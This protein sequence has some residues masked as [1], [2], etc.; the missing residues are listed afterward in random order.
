M[1]NKGIIVINKEEGYTSRD[2]VNIVSKYLK[3]KK[4]GHTGTLDPLAKGVLVVCFGK[5]TKLVPLLTSQEKTYIAE[6]KFGIKTDTLDITGKWQE[7][8][9][10]N[11]DLDKLKE[12]LN[13][14]KG[15]Y[16][17]EV[18]LYS[19]V[20]I[21]GKKLYEYARE[22]IEVTLPYKDVNIYDIKFIQYKDNIL[23]FYVV[24]EKGTYIR[25]LIKDICDKLKTIGT[26]NSLIRIKQ[27][28]FKIEDAYTL[29]DIKQGNFKILD[30]RDILEVEEYELDENIKK[31]VINGNKVHINS[32]AKYILF[33]YKRE[34]IA[35]Y[36][37]EDDIYKCYILF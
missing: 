16:H 8:Q 12:V 31:R 20:K 37:K 3:T 30:I 21:N 2:V 15:L 26:M 19:A 32:L 27:G 7:T 22:N 6:I 29:E 9:E 5:Y 1:K 18:P 10:V 28:D 23:K 13:G 17:M 25:S 11:I 4:V 34:D 36:I 14:F 33:T 35:L 24:V